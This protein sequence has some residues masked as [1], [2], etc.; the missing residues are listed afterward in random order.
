MLKFDILNILIKSLLYLCL[1]LTLQQNQIM[2][3]K[4]LILVSIFSFLMINC[5]KKDV[6]NTTI[7]SDEAKMNAQM[8]IAIDDVGRL[9]EEQFETTIATGSGK[10]NIT[11]ATSLP[12]CATMVRV[13]AV[14]TTPAVGSTVTKI[15]DF[16]STGCELA[17]GNILR[18]KIALSFIYNP[19]ATS[20]TI[21][22]TFVDFY[23]NSKKINGTKTFVRT[24][25]TAS[26]SSTSHPIVVMNLDMTMTAVDGRVFTRVGTRT[27]E[28]TA[29]YDTPLTLT[30]NIY[31]VT[32]SWT[33]TYPNT[34]VQTSTITSPLIV[35]LSC[36]PFNSAISQGVISY[37]RNTRIATLDYGNGDCDNYAVFTYN[38][39]SFNIYLKN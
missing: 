37:V 28:I 19:G 14:G 36:Y 1:I 16:G 2:K 24:M 6:D 3:P 33:T 7:T 34:I 12:A 17:N 26:G 35:N 21:T 11:T 25:T 8:D 29:G 10:S 23:H 18:G 20:H 15:I 27:C 4:L 5:S 30:D 9:V 13:P 22:Y 32:G 38:G 39:G 31:S